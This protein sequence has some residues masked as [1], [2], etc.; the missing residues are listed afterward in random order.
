[1]SN[2]A[3]NW[4]CLWAWVRAWIGFALV[5]GFYTFARSCH[6]YD[7]YAVAPCLLKVEGISELS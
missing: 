7:Q 5:T 3:F 2:L 1:M 6:E 4:S